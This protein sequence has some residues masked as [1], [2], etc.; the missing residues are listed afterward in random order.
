[1]AGTLRK[2]KTVFKPR[3][4]PKRKNNIFNSSCIVITNARLKFQRYSLNQDN[5]KEY[6]LFRA[7]TAFKI[8]SK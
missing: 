6:S 8:F 3:R 5:Q 2:K 4:I 1:M 7:T